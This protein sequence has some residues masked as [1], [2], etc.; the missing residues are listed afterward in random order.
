MGGLAS[1]VD[2][3]VTVSVIQV[4]STPDFG[5]SVHFGGLLRG[6]QLEDSQGK[7]GGHQR[8]SLAQQHLLKRAAEPSHA[9]ERS[10]AH[11]HREDHEQ[12]LERR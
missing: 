9:G 3:M 1:P 4:R 7:I 11:R 10:D 8:A 6:G 2:A 12:K 5:K